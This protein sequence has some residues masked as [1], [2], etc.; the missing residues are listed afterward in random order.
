MNRVAANYLQNSRLS[1]ALFLIYFLTK[2]FYVFGSGSIQPGDC[3]LLASFCFILYEERK[4]KIRDTEFV[5]FVTFVAAINIAYFLFYRTSDFLHSILYYIFNLIGILCFRDLMY[6]QNWMKK[7]VV[8][9]KA[10]LWIQVMCFLAHI[11]KYW[12]GTYRYMGTYTDPNQLGFAVVSTLAII[13]LMNDKRKHL[14]F[15]VAAFLIFQ[16]A[17]SGMLLALG[18]MFVLDFVNICRNAFTATF[19]RGKVFIVIGILAALLIMFAVNPVN[20]DL[21]GFR[22]EDKLSRGDSVLATFIKDRGLGAAVEHPSYFL[23]GY[24]EAAS[25]NRYGHKGEMHSTWISLSFYYGIVPFIILLKWIYRNVRGVPVK[26]IPVYAAIFLEA[27]TLINHRQ[28]SF[29]M[30]IM[31]GSLL[32]KGEENVNDRSAD[33]H[34]NTCLSG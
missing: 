15:L 8:V 34:Y 22:I 24:G 13:Y 5:L 27:F 32:G 6:D 20:I 9:C 14:Y 18:L 33:K 19:P 16:T 17:S 2:P 29:W 25:F 30:I 31:I 10:N 7:L 21:S 28:L 23:F 26:Y 12:C 1:S 3:F 11:G 4:I